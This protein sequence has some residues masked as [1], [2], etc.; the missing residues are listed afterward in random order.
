M[1]LKIVH[2]WNILIDW[3]LFS[4]KFDLQL[5]ILSAPVAIKKNLYLL[6]GKDW[7]ITFDIQK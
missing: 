5:D 7:E 1:T 2:I 3:R 6:D 4:P